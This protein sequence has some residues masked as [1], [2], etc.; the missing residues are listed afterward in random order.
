MKSVPNHRIYDES[1]K[2]YFYR[3][4]DNNNKALLDT[5][6]GGSNGE[7]TYKEIAKTLEK[8][9]RNN[10]AWRTRKLET[11]RNTFAVQATHN[12]IA[13]EIRQAIAQMRTE[14]GLVL[15]HVTRVT[16]KVNAVNYL[17]KPPPR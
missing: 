6:E 16:E 7:C 9:S 15:K 17:T 8:I 10:K 14:L 1:L 13:D 2:E 4:I 12:P 5:I 11:G 3:E